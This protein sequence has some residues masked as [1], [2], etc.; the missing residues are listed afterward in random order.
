MVE[1]LKAVLDGRVRHETYGDIRVRK[2]AAFTAL[3][4]AGAA[5]PAMLGQVGLTPREMPTAFL[6]DYLVALDRLPLA[7]GG[8]QKAAIETELRSRLVFEG[9]RLDLSDSRNQLWWMMSSSDEA[10]AKVLVAT[11]GRPGWNDDSGRMMLGVAFR[12]QRGRWDT[13]TANA[14]GAL[15]VGKFARAFPATAVAGTTNLSLGGQSQAKSW[16]LAQP[17]R[18]VSFALPAAQTPLLLRQSGGDGPW[19]TVAVRAAVPLRQ[20]LFAG[21]KLAR[22][23]TMVSQRVPGRL[24]QG[25]VMRVTLTLDAPAERNWVVIADPVPAGATILGDLGGQ[26]QLLRQGEGSSGGRAQVTID[27]KPFVVE[28]GAQPAYV[29]RT[30][31]GWRG[32]FSWVPAGR[33]VVSYTIRLNNAG[34]FSLPPTR[35][36]AMYSPAVRA[37]LPNAPVAV[38][39]R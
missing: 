13:T 20:P 14:W 3:A 37:Q 8:A 2:L 31:D 4:R 12:Q 34:R 36:E 5:T 7:N 9:T 32:Y 39:G 19:A 29:E 35:A 33:S 38:A 10:A 21:Y 25:D 16:P 22:Q 18:A 23:V 11:I 28:Y 26:S 17:Q 1:G 27:G 30:R 6:A 15:A 24:T